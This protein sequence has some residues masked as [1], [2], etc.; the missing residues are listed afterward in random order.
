MG[1]YMSEFRFDGTLPDLEAVQDEARRRLG[2]TRGIESLE[3]KG[4]KV[5]AYS[6]LDPFTHPVV[7]AILQEMGGQPV[8]HDGRPVAVTVPAWAHRPIREMAWGERMAVRYRW[9]AWLFGTARP[10]RP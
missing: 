4:Q 9:W 1:L 5:V 3:V 6:M 8:G 2:G 10:R 7:C